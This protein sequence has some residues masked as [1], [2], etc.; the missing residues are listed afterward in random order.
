MKSIEEAICSSCLQDAY[1]CFLFLPCHH[2][3]LVLLACCQQGMLSI[4]VFGLSLASLGVPPS[5]LCYPHNCHQT[6]KKTDLESSHRQM[7]TP[8][9]RLKI[10]GSR[11]TNH[12]VKK[13]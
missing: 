9:A 6:K 12:E 4:T 5:P 7:V 13:K 1:P 3:L 8:L 10:C 2:A 11:H